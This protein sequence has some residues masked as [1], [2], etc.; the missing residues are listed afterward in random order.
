MAQPVS[1]RPRLGYWKKMSLDDVR[2]AIGAACRHSANLDRFN[3]ISTVGDRLWVDIEDMVA[4][5]FNNKIRSFL[6]IRDAFEDDVPEAYL[7]AERE[8]YEEV[9]QIDDAIRDGRRVNGL[10]EGHI[11]NRIM[12]VDYL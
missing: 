2:E 1:F 4:E 8:F 10:K 6:G 12:E 9:K 7:V 11:V 3:A 5:V